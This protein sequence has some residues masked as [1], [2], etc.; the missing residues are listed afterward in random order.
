L[1][2]CYSLGQFWDYFVFM[3]NYF[4]DNKYKNECIGQHFNMIFKIVN[5]FSFTGK[6]SNKTKSKRT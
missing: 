5:L 1:K 4:E 2:Q 3:N 6:K